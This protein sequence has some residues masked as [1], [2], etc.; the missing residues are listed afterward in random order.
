MKKRYYSQRLLLAGL[1]AASLSMG[2]GSAQ[3]QAGR[4]NAGALRPD[5]VR[6]NAARTNVAR[7]NAARTN[8]ARKKAVRKL[9]RG[10]AAI[11][12]NGRRFFYHE[13]SFYSKGQ[14]GYIFVAAPLGAV[15]KR[16]PRGYKVM[17]IRGKKYF[18]YDGVFY[19][20]SNRGYRVVDAPRGYAGGQVRITIPFVGPNG[21]FL[22]I[23]GRWV[24][25]NA[26]ARYREAGRSVFQT[27][28]FPES[29]AKRFEQRSVERVA[30]RGRTMGR[31]SGTIESSDRRGNR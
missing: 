18:R 11:R 31:N 19:L 16:L 9:P 29:G 3:A 30:P 23:H 24:W 8:V 4:Q 14:S 21:F 6:A 27:R 12:V 2:A 10:N 26:D 15:V 20:K 13:G 1:V 5:V 7:K 28:R 17:R 22:P 25:S